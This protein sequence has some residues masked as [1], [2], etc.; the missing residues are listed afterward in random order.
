MSRDRGLEKIRLAGNEA[1]PS[2]KFGMLT[3]M[4]KARF[5]QEQSGFTYQEKRLFTSLI[6]TADVLQDIFI[7]Q[8]SPLFS[9]QT[10]CNVN[11]IAIE[12]VDIQRKHPLELKDIPL[13][14]Q[15]EYTFLKDLIAEQEA[16][17]TN[18]LNRFITLEKINLQI[19]EY[20]SWNLDCPLGLTEHSRRHLNILAEFNKMFDIQF[21]RMR[22]QYNSDNQWRLLY[23]FNHLE[24][25]ERYFSTNFPASQL[26]DTEDIQ[27]VFV[28]NANEQ[29]VTIENVLF[30]GYKKE[31]VASLRR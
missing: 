24:Q 1:M 3:S 2:S 28:S 27:P 15:N 26:L 10:S 8:E 12:L 29:Q 18:S 7:S 13:T 5:R 19:R 22:N 14:Q 17:R 31:D 30:S 20:L 11:G 9:S 4:I 25:F 6:H 16:A 21:D 23:I